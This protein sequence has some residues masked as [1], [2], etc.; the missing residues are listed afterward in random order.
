MQIPF[1]RIELEVVN[2]QY[3]VEVQISV[4]RNVLLDAKATEVTQIFRLVFAI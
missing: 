4:F 3:I 1:S 2:I